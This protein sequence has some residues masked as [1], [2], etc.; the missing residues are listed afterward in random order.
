MPDPDPK[1]AKHSGR[2]WTDIVS[3]EKFG[4]SVGYLTDRS[5]PWSKIPF[6]TVL[7]P[8]DRRSGGGLDLTS[9]EQLE[10]IGEVAAI[11]KRE[12]GKYACE[13][14]L[15][16]F[17]GS[18]AHITIRDSA[19]LEAIWKKQPIF[20]GKRMKLVSKGFP[21]K[22]ITVYSVWGVRVMKKS[23]LMKSI[24]DHTK[25][26][27]AL[28]LASMYQVDEVGGEKFYKAEPIFSGDMIFFGR[29]TI[30]FFVP[31]LGSLLVVRPPEDR[32]KE[33][34][35]QNDPRLWHA[36]QTL[37]ENPDSLLTS[38]SICPS[39]LNLKGALRN[40]VS[41]VMP[42]RAR[43]NSKTSNNSQVSTTYFNAASSDAST[44]RG[45][46]A[47]AG[48]ACAGV[49]AT[50]DAALHLEATQDRAHDG[51][52]QSSD[53]KVRSWWQ[54]V[55]GE[56]S[57]F[58]LSYVSDQSTPLSTN[59]FETVFKLDDSQDS[60]KV[61]RLHQERN[62]IVR[63]I[64]TIFKEVCPHILNEQPFIHFR[65][66]KVHVRF[67]SPSFLQA[68]WKAPPSFKGKPMKL[69]S[70]GLAK[71]GIRVYTACLPSESMVDLEK[72][73]KAKTF[74][75]VEFILAYMYDVETLGGGPIFYGDLVLICSAAMTSF[76]GEACYEARYPTRKP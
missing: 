17:N 71:G 41:P 4:L 56:S 33:D 31:S 62:E 25:E 49:T 67:H 50:N 36:E 3:G 23:D 11:F 21:E 54:T 29:A 61:L 52:T 34:R 19:L 6:E 26:P 10:I 42:K 14:P 40:L 74:P 70:K 12:K 8:H 2:M 27:A 53:L 22:D 18:D 60:K 16:Y 47:N 55:Y 46:E 24:P 66:Q 63:A 69:V 9:D 45:D 65:H 35:T 48:S 5:A 73:L 7:R 57:G 68:L 32:N 39:H 38:H 20:R 72:R 44:I 13:T 76:L 64:A 59:A 51:T 75:G 28:I 1:K 37:K 30:S 15:I 43:T 58:S